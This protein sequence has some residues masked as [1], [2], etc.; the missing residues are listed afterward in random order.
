MTSI[1]VHFKWIASNFRSAIPLCV[2]SEQHMEAFDLMGCCNKSYFLSA[3]LQLQQIDLRLGHKL[4]INMDL[5]R[6]LETGSR[7]P[8]GQTVV[9]QSQSR[10]S[11]G[12]QKVFSIV[13]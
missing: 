7:N 1:F 10:T 11:V 6:Q 5:L 8:T 9:L 3:N 12:T 13:K 2:V 4:D